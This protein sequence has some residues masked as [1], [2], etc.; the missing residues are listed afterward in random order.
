M[1][2]AEKPL[3]RCCGEVGEQVTGRDFEGHG[4]PE[5]RREARDGGAALEIGHEAGGEVGGV[6]EPLLAHAALLTK[7]P[8]PFAEDLGFLNCHADMRLRA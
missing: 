8:Q 6:R 2:S 7:T 3:Q 5:N 1:A 4:Q